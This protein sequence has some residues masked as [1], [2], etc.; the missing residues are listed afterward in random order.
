EVL[1][2]VLGALARLHTGAQPEL[3]AMLL[4]LLGKE[5]PRVQ[6]GAAE[7]LGRVGDVTV[8]ER[9]R[10]IIAS[11][12][13]ARVLRAAIVAVGRLEGAAAT[14]YLVDIHVQN[15]YPGVVQALSEV[16]DARAV[17]EMEKWSKK[18]TGS[19]LPPLL[20]ALEAVKRR[21]A[22]PD[23][24]STSDRPAPPTTP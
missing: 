20:A 8:S 21:P 5:H 7:A 17:P 15:A 24:A 1:P 12:C 10:E 3:Q 13:D 16:G 23:V 9:L 19:N 6:A 11:K 22:P 18:V 14:P 2:G 4:P